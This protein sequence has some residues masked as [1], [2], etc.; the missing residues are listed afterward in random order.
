M[1]LAVFIRL[2]RRLQHTRCA[3]YT[4]HRARRHLQRPG[5]V[6]R[7][8][9]STQTSSLSSWRCRS[10]ETSFAS[11]YGTPPTQAHERRGAD[12][13]AGA[14]G[15]PGG[16]QAEWDWAVEGVARRLRDC[17]AIERHGSE[18]REA[19]FVKVLAANLDPLSALLGFDPGK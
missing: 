11:R 16:A 14:V 9:R 13:A 19:E 15:Q 2:W 4:L 18:E 3:R 5:P 7:L 8:G 17:N 12:A 1:Q 10:S 6:R